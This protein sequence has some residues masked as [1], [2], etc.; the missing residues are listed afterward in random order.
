MANNQKRS[1][2]TVTGGATNYVGKGKVTSGDL[3]YGLNGGTNRPSVNL[4]SGGVISGATVLSGGVAAA[5]A[6]GTVYGGTAYESG[7]IAALNQAL[8]SARRLHREQVSLSV[9]FL[10][11]KEHRL[12]RSLLMSWPEDTRLSEVVSRSKVKPLQALVWSRVER[13]TWD[14]PSSS[15]AAGPIA[16]ASSVGRRSFPGAAPR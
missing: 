16:A 4:A 9:I 8:S 10:V 3:V 2:A 11:T 14:R 15:P 12:R 6:N 5:A 13:L 1:G 7:S